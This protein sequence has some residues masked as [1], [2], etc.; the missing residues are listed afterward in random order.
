MPA[1]VAKLNSIVEEYL[2]DLRRLRASGGAT[3]ELSTYPALSNLLNAV[4]RR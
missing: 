2:T 3:G 1:N 4:A